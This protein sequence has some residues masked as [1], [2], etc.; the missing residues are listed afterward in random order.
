MTLCALPDGLLAFSDMQVS[1]GRKGRGLVQRHE[2]HHDFLE[3]EQYQ[4]CVRLYQGIK[5]IGC[6]IGTTLVL[7]SVEKEV[8]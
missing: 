6:L 4:L 5:V 8:L 2:Y 3:I 1:E 7:F